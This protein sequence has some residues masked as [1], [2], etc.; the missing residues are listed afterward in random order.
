MCSAFRPE[1]RIPEV[2]NFWN[3]ELSDP[4]LLKTPSGKRPAFQAGK[5]KRGSLSPL[6]PFGPKTPL[7]S[8]EDRLS[9]GTPA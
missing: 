4:N 1:F 7:E 3:L 9:G 2:M 8:G 6:R 5:Q